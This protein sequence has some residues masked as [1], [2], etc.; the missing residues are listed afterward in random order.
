MTC[1]AC[2]LHTDAVN[3]CLAA[4]GPDNPDVLFIGEAPGLREDEAGKPFVDE[5]GQLLRKELAGCGFSYR[6]TNTV[7]CSPP[8]NRRPNAKEWKT[9]ASEHL[10]KEIEATN[11]KLIVPLGDVAMRA[12]LGIGG[13]LKNGGQVYM[14]EVDKRQ[15][16]P[17][18]HPSYVL[19]EPSYGLKWREYLFAIRRIIAPV[20]TRVKQT[21]YLLDEPGEIKR[22]V[23]DMIENASAVAFDY[24]TTDLNPWKGEVI[25]TAISSVEGVAY[26]FDPVKHRRLWVKFLRSGVNKVVQHAPFESI[27]SLVHFGTLPK[28]LVWDTKLGAILE[29]EEKP[30]TLKHMAMVETDMGDYSAEIRERMGE[31]GKDFRGGFSEAKIEDVWRYNCG[32]AD[33]TLRVMRVQS[34]RCTKDLPEELPEDARIRLMAQSLEYVELLTKLRNRGVRVKDNAIPQLHA[35]ITERLGQITSDLPRKHLTVRMLEKQQGQPVNPASAPQMRKLFFD[36]CGL[37]P[38]ATSEKTGMPS[39]SKEFLKRNKDHAVCADILEW[40]TIDQI[41]KNFLEPL[42]KE[43]VDG[44]VHPEWNVGGARTFRLSCSRPN[45]QNIP[46]DERVRALFIPRD[47]NVFVQAD[48]SQIELRVMASLTKDPVF[49]DAF[50]RG[51]D[52]HAETAAKRNK[53]RVSQVSKEMRSRAKNVNFGVL[54]GITAGGMEA[55]FNIPKDEAQRMLDQFWES[56][57]DVATWI[58]QQHEMATTRGFVL[59]PFGRTRHL[60]DA[61]LPR[62]KQNRGAINRALRQAGNMPIQS[63]AAE[64]TLLACG[65]IETEIP[66]FLFG[67]IHDSTLGECPRRYG[68]KTAR[69]TKELMEAIGDKLDWVLTPLK[70]D[71][72]IGKDWFRMEEL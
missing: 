21:Y 17:L 67:Q 2:P 64:I 46:H 27:W 19:R 32:D 36:T 49:L 60:E 22:I 29:H 61:M 14:R 48:Y 39:T 1:T 26:C 53:I 65:D 15:V 41:R 72:E 25:S 35:D 51:V 8:G 50:E 38:I 24:E 9:C 4:E 10:A 13:P 47:G 42:E 28:K 54:Y 11:P 5:A 34:E 18:A 3:V 37:E 52:P 33:A 20:K 57:P 23:D 7:R 59:S 55:K 43:A 40:K 63:A 31:E 68:R 66:N 71:V 69:I 62:T 70:V 12:V 16:Y 45:L 58:D 6:L 30:N 56:H 44:F